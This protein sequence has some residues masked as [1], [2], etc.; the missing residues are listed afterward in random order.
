MDDYKYPHVDYSKTIVNS[1]EHDVKKTFRKLERTSIKLITT[2]AHNS[3]NETC[4]NN[5]LLPNYSHIYIC[6]SVLVGDCEFSGRC[7]F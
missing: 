1:L 3:F 2:I 6:I 4:L 5:S 7:I